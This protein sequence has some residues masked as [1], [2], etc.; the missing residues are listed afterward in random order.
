[1]N[2]VLQPFLDKFMVVY[3]D[4]II[5][6]NKTLKEHVVHLK[7]VMEALREH[8]LFVKKEKYTFAFKRYL[9]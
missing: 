9:S 2:K 4:D 7:Q 3:Y 8:E 5:I 6:Y 1:M